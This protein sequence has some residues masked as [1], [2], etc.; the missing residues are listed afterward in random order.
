MRLIIASSLVVS[1][2]FLLFSLEAK[3]DDKLEAILNANPDT[4]K[5]KSLSDLCWEYR[6]K[7]ADSA[8]IFGEKALSLAQSLHYTKGI[9]QAY[10]DLGIVYINNAN[11]HRATTYLNEALKIRQQLNDFSGI[12]SIHNKLGIIDQKQGRLKEALEHQISALKI[13]QQLGQDKWIGYSL[14]NIA[15]IHNNLGNLS[16]ALEYHQKAL[17]YRIKLDDQEGEATSYGN[18]ANLYSNLKDTV[19]AVVFYEKAIA[20]SRELKKDE[21]ISANLSNMANIYM[22]RK[23]YPE[24]LKLYSESLRIREQIEDTKGISSTLSRMGMVYTQTGKYRDAARVLKRAY[25]LAKEIAVIDEELSALLGLAKLKAITNQPD[26]SFV[27]MEN[28]IN[29]KD[30]VYDARIKQQILDVQSQY[31]TVKLEQDLELIKK[32]KAYTE[33]KLSQQKTQIWLLIFVFISLTGAG[34]FLFY[35]HQQRQEAALQ[36]ERLAEQEMRM[37][38]IFQAQ[39]E[40]RR[41]IAKELHDG[42]G[43]TISAIKMNFQSLVR[44]SENSVDSTEY[45]KIEKM[46]DHVGSEVRSIS[47]QMIPKE[48][49]QFGLVP[50]VEGM[51]SLNLDKSTLKYEFEH[52]GFNDRIGNHIELVLF[53]VLQELVSNVLKHSKATFLNVQLVK[54]KTHVILNVTDNG[55]GFNVGSHEKSGI[56]LLNIA[57]RID[58]I[59]GHLHYESAPGS[60]T[61]V[62]IRTPIL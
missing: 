33:I 18:M 20:L 5:V 11:Y 25:L 24:A 51:L 39:E 27:L 61:T 43:Q 26:S 41:R 42:V 29:A 44:N 54:V 3:C 32:E 38:A 22:A 2:L 13:Y 30:S 58:G 59:N 53:R 57:S 8:I 9:A 47:H 16:K 60:G 46:I 14:N 48:L 28:Y 21:L 52:S 56:G 45:Q 15:I 12:A 40:E 7:S 17:E 34:I 62:T 37:N 36:A 4:N 1:V 23:N 10:N 55:V 19:Q 31:E 35:R 50:A 6:Y 49:E